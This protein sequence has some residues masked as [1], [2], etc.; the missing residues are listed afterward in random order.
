MSTK[1][2][3]V[4][5]GSGNITRADIQVIGDVQEGGYRG[6]VLPIARKHK[7]KGFV[8]NI[9]DGTVRIVAEG[10]EK[11]LKKFI[12]EIDI[13]NGMIEVEKIEVAFSAPT[14]E[15]KWFA[16]KTSGL[17][18]EMFQGF[19]TAKKYLDRISHQITKGNE[20]LK[21]GIDTVA[22]KIDKGFEK[23]NDN[24][25]G[26]DEKYHTV[27]DELEGIRK[28]LEK[29]L[30]IEEEKVKYSAEKKKSLEKEQDGDR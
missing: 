30:S 16:V 3:S 29:R 13:H 19:G 11:S 24:F 5:D 25:Q 27:S 20:E 7:L 8:E 22:Q 2:D 10:S 15:F 14:G 6:T 18:Y 21:E 23:T 28:A 1:T 4:D 12:E 26:L 9:P 17:G